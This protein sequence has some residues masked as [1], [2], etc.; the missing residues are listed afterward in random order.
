MNLTTSRAAM[1]ATLNG[2]LIREKEFFVAGIGEE[3][4]ECLL[5]ALRAFN[6]P[7]LSELREAVHT[8]RGLS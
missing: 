4:Y 8:E 5:L 7:S 1:Y 6:G 3:E 2:W